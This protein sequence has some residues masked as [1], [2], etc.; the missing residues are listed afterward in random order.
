[1]K[2]ILW[3][4]ANVKNQK[5]LK[6]GFYH[7]EASA[8]WI[9]F[10]LKKVKLK[11][12]DNI[13][14]INKND[15]LI[16][17]DSGLDEKKTLYENLSSICSKIFLFHLGDEGGTEET[18]SI[19]NNCTHV[20]RTFCLNRY[21]NNLKITCIPL[22]FKTGTKLSQ[23]FTF[24]KRKYSWS[25]IGTAHKS[26]RHDLLY[27]LDSVLPK[28]V[29]KT[30]K[31]ND[32]KRLT[33]EKFSSVLSDSKFIPCPSGF[34]HP[35]TYRLY[36]ALECKCIPIIEN[37]YNFYD[38]FFPDNPFIKVNL[39]KESLELI[40]NMEDKKILETNDRCVNWWDNIKKNL[41]KSISKKI[42]NE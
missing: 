22:G 18:F 23:N 16:I 27:Q 38:R 32:K 24:L 30:E 15:E 1:M 14:E 29:F 5:S 17:I 35:E 7:Q 26:C 11:Q 21:F 6:W 3:N 31:F 10:L 8:E 2:K 39:W 25:F 13:D 20:W 28:F 33:I 4:T 9:L 36:E 37:L 34:Y 19:Y 40:N 42:Y 41:Q 12:I